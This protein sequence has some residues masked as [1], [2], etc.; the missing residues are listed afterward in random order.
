MILIEETVR[1]EAA[2]DLSYYSSGIPA[3]DAFV[4]LDH[5]THI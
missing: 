4:E 5:L 3:R 1:A 2:S